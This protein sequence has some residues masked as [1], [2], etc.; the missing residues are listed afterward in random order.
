MPTGSSGGIAEYA[1]DP[2]C[3]EIEGQHAIRVKSENAIKPL[4]Q[5]ICSTRRTGSK[6]L[7]N[8]RLDLSSCDCGQV[9]P[10]G[11]IIEPTN[12]IGGNN[13]PPGREGAQYVGIE[14]PAIRIS[15]SRRGDSSRSVSMACGISLNRS[16]KLGR[17]V[18]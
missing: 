11:T 1:G 18:G 14:Q 17:L 8:A 2:C 4:T 9:Q 3:S 10:L 16:T 6:K 13:V 15:T 5:C 7:R 12:R